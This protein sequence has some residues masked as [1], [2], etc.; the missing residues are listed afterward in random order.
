MTEF[1]IRELR[2]IEELA[3]TEELNCIV[4]GQDDLPD[5]KDL[6]R[7]LQDEGGL[8]AG[9]FTPAH[10]LA[11]YLFAFPTRNPHVQHSH[12]L[13]VHPTYRK[14]GLG[15]RLKWFQRDWCL[16][17]GLQLVRWTFDPLRSVNAHLN[18]HKLGATANTYKENYY[19][20]MP[21]INAGAPSDRLVAEW[22]LNDPNV[23]K[24]SNQQDFLPTTQIAPANEVIN[25][26]PV[27]T[28]LELDSN[29]TI[30]IPNDF[31]ALLAANQTLAVHWREHSREVFGHYFSRGYRLTDFSFATSSYTLQQLPLP[32]LTPTRIMS[33]E[34]LAS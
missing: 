13:G 6:L 33:G 24:R 5:D 9:A 31:A 15:V 7:A 2:G 19:G 14:Y 16:A 34:D 12:K 26:K 3:L 32:P 21:G 4:W 27:R 22:F 29:V 17:R 28:F 1:D 30:E 20:V 11:A 25:G 8:L 18:I 10:E 23:V